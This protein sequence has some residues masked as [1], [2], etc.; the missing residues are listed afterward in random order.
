M[1][2]TDDATASRCTTCKTILPKQYRYKTCESCRAKG[3]EHNRRAAEKR[4]TQ[5]KTISLALSSLISSEDELSLVSDDVADLKR[6]RDPKDGVIVQS[7][8]QKTVKDFLVDRLESSSSP[9]PVR[10]SLTQSREVIL[11]IYIIPG[12]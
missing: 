9:V 1:S 10:L 2:A 12:S 4:K 7:K 6:K 3:R 5:E 8:K 11:L